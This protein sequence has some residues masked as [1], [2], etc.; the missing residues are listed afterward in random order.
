MDEI[1]KMLNIDSLDESKQDEI[2]TKLNDIVQLKIDEKVSEKETELKDQLTEQ[3]EE[4]F[5]E[6]KNDLTEKFSNFLDE[7]LDEELHIPDDIKEY[8]RKGQLY[9]DII[10]NLKVR[11]GI[12]EGLLDDEAKEIMSEAKEEIKK[13]QSEQNKIVSENMELKSDAKELSAH[14]YLTEKCSELTLPQKE[15]AM[16]LLEGVKDKEEIDRK[17]SIIVESNDEETTDDKDTD[18][19]EE[20]EETNDK[21]TDLNE[22]NIYTFWNHMLSQKK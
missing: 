18:L 22:N 8:A 5:T 19:N 12:D 14:I 1:L 7:V 2:K 17:I 13:L 11:I 10:E 6:Y 3:Y 21:D 4:K 20:V 16:K 15:K 9:S